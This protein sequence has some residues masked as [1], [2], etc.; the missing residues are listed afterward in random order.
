MVCV[1]AW[2]HACGWAIIFVTHA[3]SSSS[4][5]STPV[6]TVKPLGFSKGPGMAALLRW[7]SKMKADKRVSEQ[8]AV[9]PDGGAVFLPE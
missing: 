4:S 8:M 2:V 6:S 1:G 5:P 3:V 7:H 9:S